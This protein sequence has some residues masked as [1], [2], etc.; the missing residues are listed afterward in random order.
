MASLRITASFTLPLL[1]ISGLALQRTPGAPLRL[2]AIGDESFVVVS[3]P[4]EGGEPTGEAEQHDLGA[5]LVGVAK[6]GGSQWEAIAC[7]AEGRVLIL[8]ESPGTVFVLDPTL[9]RLLATITLSAGAGEAGRAWERDGNSRGEGLVPLSNGHLLVVKEKDPPQLVELGPRGAS[10]S[11]VTPALCAPSAF[12]LPAGAQSEM[13]TLAC[14]ELTGD[15]LDD[16]DDLSDIAV[17]PDGALHLVSDQA[18]CLLRIDP[19]LS[20]DGGA[21]RVTGRWE[22]PKKIKK[23]EGLVITEARRPLVAVDQDEERENL[24]LLD[25]LD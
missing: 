21:A 7:D 3:V 9:R 25:P 19:S 10:S 17:G 24:F 8:Q 6:K 20:P 13:V 11:G 5:L 2:L 18:R 22:L 4:M 1:E 23:P 14:W 15:D 16:L 12:P